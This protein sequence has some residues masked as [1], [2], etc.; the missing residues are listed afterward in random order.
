M[1]IGEVFN[2]YSLAACILQ[3]LVVLFTIMAVFGPAL[4]TYVA[5]EDVF[6]PASFISL[7]LSLV[8]AVIGSYKIFHTESTRK[9]RII[10]VV[11]IV[12]SPILL[13][14]IIFSIIARFSMG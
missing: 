8:F 1:K 5:A 14:G 9:K 13:I 12:F 10:S 2:N 11:L 7:A 6:V 3:I 4:S